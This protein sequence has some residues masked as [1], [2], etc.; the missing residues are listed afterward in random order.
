MKTK[1]FVFIILGQLFLISFLGYRIYQKKE[2]VLGTRSVKPITKE[3]ID[4]KPSGELK[5]FYEPKSVAQF[6][7]RDSSYTINSDTLCQVPIFSTTFSKTF[8]S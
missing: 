7:F 6:L 3:S 4:L 8:C 2:N 1:L 5:Y